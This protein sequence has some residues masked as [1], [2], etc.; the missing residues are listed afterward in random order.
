MLYNMLKKLALLL[1]V[2]QLS[3]CDTLQSILNEGLASQ[4]LT[5]AE[6]VA[7][8]KQALE[9]GATEGAQALS[10]Q[11]GYLKS[12]YKILLPPEA[13]A[14]T[15]RLQNVPGFSQVENILLEKINRGAE[16]A[17]KRAAP[18]FRSA[19]TSMSVNDAL[20]ILT[21]EKDAATQ[22]LNRTTSNQLYNEFNPVII[23]SLDKFDARKYWRDAVTAY[24]KIPFVEKAN[25]SLDDYVTRQALDGL[26]KMVA[27]KELDIRTNLSARSTDLLRKVFA[28]QD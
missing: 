15:D 9:I 11:D 4:A 3:S 28:R 27:V 1:L 12:P 20:G 23:Q 5:N 19:I 8:L 25:P 22:Y 17:A 18:I 10:R 16:D 21:G 14:I 7:G 13:R 6:I 2:L 26:F 24:N